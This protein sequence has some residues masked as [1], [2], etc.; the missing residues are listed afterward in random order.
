MYCTIRQE[1]RSDQCSPCNLLPSVPHSAK[2]KIKRIFMNWFCFGCVKSITCQL[3]VN[4]FSSKLAAAFEAVGDIIDPD[5]QTGK[6]LMTNNPTA[7]HWTELTTSSFSCQRCR[8]RFLRRVSCF[9]FAWMPIGHVKGFDLEHTK[10]AFI[11]LL[12]LRSFWLVRSV[13]RKQRS[14]WGFAQGGI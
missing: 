13:Y 6:F 9:I 10:D 4:N 11:Y 1:I 7:S 8:H 14:W 3:T 2:E 5:V 12:V